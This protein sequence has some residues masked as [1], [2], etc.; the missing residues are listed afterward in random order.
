MTSSPDRTGVRRPVPS[1]SAGRVRTALLRLML[2]AMAIRSTR[3]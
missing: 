1:P 3:S 2:T